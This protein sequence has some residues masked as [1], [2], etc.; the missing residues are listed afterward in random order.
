MWLDWLNAEEMKNKIQ[1]NMK[2]EFS[3]R[4]LP[5][6]S[7]E[8]WAIKDSQ[9]HIVRFFYHPLWKW[10]TETL[11]P[12]SGI[13]KIGLTYYDAYKPLEFPLIPNDLLN[14]KP[15]ETKTETPN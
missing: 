2:E 3:H 4:L 9:I 8:C 12:I 15:Q 14:K 6:S 5:M 10:C 13:T 7:L 11:Y 1:E